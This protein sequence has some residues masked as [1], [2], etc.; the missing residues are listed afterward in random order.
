MA[1]Y[2]IAATY[3]VDGLKGLMKDGGTGR[4]AAIEELLKSVDGSL[5]C[6]YY[7][8]GGKDAYLVVDVPS[9]EAAAAIGMV[10]GA[11]GGASVETTVLLTP[12]Q[13]DAARS[14]TPQYRP[15][16]G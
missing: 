14:M 12:E 6:L 13:V 3:S 4:R 1:K 8:F 11:A 10:V 16:G 7:A 15:P 9:N 5:E 2:L